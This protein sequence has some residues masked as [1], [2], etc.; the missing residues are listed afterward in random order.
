[1]VHDVV[2]FPDFPLLRLVKGCL[3]YTSERGDTAG[4]LALL[5]FQ[6]VRGMYLLGNILAVHPVSYT[7]LDKKAAAF[8]A[9]ACV[10]FL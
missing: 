3:L 2:D 1:M 9:A 5:G 4:K 7:H 8:S 6:K 10:T